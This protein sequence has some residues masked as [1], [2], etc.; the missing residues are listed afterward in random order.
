MKSAEK[1]KE[2][3]IA[4]VVSDTG[5]GIPKAQQDKIY[6]ASRRHVREKIRTELGLGCTSLNPLLIIPAA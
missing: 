2:D 6:Q 5:Y 1:V 3:S 4:I